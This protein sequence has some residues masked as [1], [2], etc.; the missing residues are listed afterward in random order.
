MAGK[1]FYYPKEII[2][3]QEELARPEHREVRIWLEQECIE[4]NKLETVMGMLA[5]RLGIL[6]NGECLLTDVARIL[7]EKLLEIR[8]KAAPDIITDAANA[9]KATGSQV[10]I[11]DQFGS[12]LQH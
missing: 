5:A 4:M 9:D 8:R 7:A 2:Q 12:K 11:L 1:L 3:L 10:I 6:I